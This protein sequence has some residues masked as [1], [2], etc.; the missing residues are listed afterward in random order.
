MVR[1]FYVAQHVRLSL[2]GRLAFYQFREHAAHAVQLVLAPFLD[3]LPIVQNGDLASAPAALPARA[4]SR[5]PS[6][7]WFLRQQSTDFIFSIFSEE[8]GL[9]GGLLV[10]VC[11][12]ENAVS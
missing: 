8:W 7:Y 2:V 4:I 1:F 5:A 9:P 11:C 3:D 12:R 10:F 6:H